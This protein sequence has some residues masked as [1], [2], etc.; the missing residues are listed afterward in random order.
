VLRGVQ[1][2]SCRDGFLVQRKKIVH[3]GWGSTTH[4][5][6]ETGLPCSGWLSSSPL[7]HSGDPDDRALVSLTDVLFPPLSKPSI[8][9]N[10][11]RN[12]RMSVREHQ[13]NPLP[14]V[15]SVE[16]TPE[17]EISPCRHLSCISLSRYDGVVHSARPR[18]TKPLVGLSR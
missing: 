18:Q 13:H 1:D 8:R 10:Q 3:H 2:A 15:Q 16:A 6:D 4:L 9:R 17:R 12:E 7:P 5:V 14:V 11:R